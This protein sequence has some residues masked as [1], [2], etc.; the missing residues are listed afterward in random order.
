LP[1]QKNVVN[2]IKQTAA[3]I[4]EK[5][6]NF[7][8][9]GIGGSALG[10]IAL[11]TSLNNIYYNL[12]DKSTRNNC[13]R[14]FFPDNVDPE[15]FKELLDLIDIKKSC[16]N[17][18]SKS[19]GTVET[20][21]C[22]SI[23]FDLIKKQLGE[24][25]IPKHIIATTDPQKGLLRQIATSHNI[26]IFDIPPNVGGRFS[27]LSSVGLLPAAV[28]GIDID[29]LLAGAADMDK[30]TQ[31]IDLFQNP[32]YL[33]AVLHFL[34]NTK[35]NKIIS[36]M[37]PY[38][39]ALYNFADW[40]RQ[41]WAESLGKRFSVDGRKIE[42]GQTPIKALG[43][44]DQHSQIQLYIE[45]PNDKVIT[46]IAVEKF[47]TKSPIPVIGGDFEQLDYLGNHDL[48]ELLNTELIAT[49]TALTN[50][51]RPNCKI[52]FDEISPYNIGQFIFMYEVQT[53]FS[54]GL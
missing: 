30:K 37:M 44:T 2:G 53:A 39:N 50:N 27:V 36:V 13:P 41:I 14:M 22:F 48:A 45:G 11:H 38:S 24:S 49:E 35:K 19:G 12:S 33:N 47:R 32:A 26:K 23:I 28:E 15:Y 8:V 43:A 25:A 3:Q 31:S 5:F 40:Y 16:F 20:M 51:H 6:E 10:A 42:V 18:I 17:I 1:Y 7:I 21:A 29:Q 4:R 46:L 52:I 9:I 54:G 34:L